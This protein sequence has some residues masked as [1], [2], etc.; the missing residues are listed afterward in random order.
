MHAAWLQVRPT[1]TISAQRLADQWRSLKK[2]NFFTDVELEAIARVE[3][4]ETRGAENDV[5]ES[6]TAPGTDVD[7]DSTR[8]CTVSWKNRRS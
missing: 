8:T 7:Q 2:S 4:E 6:L 1:S 3:Q 5:D